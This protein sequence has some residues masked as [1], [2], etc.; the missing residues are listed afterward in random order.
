MKGFKITTPDKQDIRLEFYLDTAPITFKA[1][2]EIIP[3]TMVFNLTKVSRQE[4]WID[5]VPKLDIIQENESVFT[6]PP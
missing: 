3:F 2:A 4:I 6:K 1:F 5:N